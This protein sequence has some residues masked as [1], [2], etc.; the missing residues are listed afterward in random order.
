MKRAGRKYIPLSTEP[1]QISL[2]SRILAGSVVTSGSSTVIPQG[3]RVDDYDF[4]SSTF[5]HEWD[6]TDSTP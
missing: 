3:Q 1:L 2:E 4:S 6:V 5:S